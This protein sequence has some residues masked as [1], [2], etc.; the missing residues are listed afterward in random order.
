MR[1]WQ[2]TTDRRTPLEKTGV[3]IWFR[4]VAVPA[5]VPVVSGLS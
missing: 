2:K 1:C 4:L 5:A 3:V